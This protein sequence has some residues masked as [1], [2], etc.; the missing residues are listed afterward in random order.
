M[1][2]KIKNIEFLFKKVLTLFIYVSIIL[3]IVKNTLKRMEMTLMKCFKKFMPLILALVLVLSQATSALACTGVYVGSA[4]SENGSTY[5]GRSE[6]IGDL[7]GKMYGV[8]ASKTIAEGEL[9]KDTY[10]FVMDYDAIDFDYPQQTYKYTYVKDTPNYGET[11]MDED[12]NPVGEAYAEAGQNEKGVSMTATVSTNYN[13]DAKA[14]DPLVDTGI[15]EISMTSIV[16]GG[17]AT[18]KEG[19]EL[20]A[21]IIDEYGAGECNSIMLSDADETWYVEIVSGHQYAAIKMPV[22]KVSIQPNIMLLGA[23]DVTDTDNVIASENLVKLAEDNGFLETDANGNIHVAKT[24]ARENAGK[25][26]YSRYW[27]GLYYVNETAAELIK[28][29]VLATNMSTDPLPLLVDSTDKL[30]TLDVLQLLAYRGEGTDMDSN[31]TNDSYYAIGNN[32]QAECHIFETRADMPAELATIQWQAM[33]DAEFSIY[34]PYYSAL[35]TEVHE[36]YGNDTAK[37][38]KDNV[39][40][41]EFLAKVEDSINWNFQIINNLCY[42]NR[43]LCAENVSAYF[44]TW[45]ESLIQQQEDIDALMLEVYEYDK[46]LAAEKATALGKDLAQQTLEM[47]NSVLA[48]LL[49][50]LETENTEAFVPSAMTE[51]VM[52][53][54]SFDNVGGTGLPAGDEP[55]VPGPGEGDE[56]DDPVVPGPGEGDDPVVPGPGEGDEGDDPV[57]PGPGEGEQGTTDDK[58]P[59]DKTP[60]DKEDADNKAPVTGD[61]TDMMLYMALVI[62][63]AGAAVALKKKVE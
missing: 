47:T 28:N 35:V 18:A 14:A 4:V 3:T 34:L 53:V 45:Q 43:A 25:G 22:D 48:E 27:Q 26:Q 16:L 23:I 11:M 24:Y 50:Y 59:A 57:V 6:D 21:A 8:A 37:G 49:A 17:A 61:A 15:C 32:R 30:S 42:S 40:S 56:G 54:Y 44:E 19:V 60:A 13:N 31:A 51:E 33:A 20:L 7:Y 39:T 52:P 9:Y 36:G 2:K 38:W 10:G 5:M 55:V 63:A 1:E 29:T 46:E 62:M 41:D 58:E 12:G